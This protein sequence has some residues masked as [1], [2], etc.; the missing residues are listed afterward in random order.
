MTDNLDPG[1]RFTNTKP[2]LFVGATRRDG[3]I[4]VQYVYPMSGRRFTKIITA[5]RLAE[6]RASGSYTIV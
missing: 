3:K 4:K 6:D 1:R 2:R 5:E